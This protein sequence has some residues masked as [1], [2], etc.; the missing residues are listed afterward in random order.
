MVRITDPADP[1]VAEYVRVK[2]ADLVKRRGLFLAEGVEVVRT[3]VTRSR[4]GVR[5]LFVSERR[6]GAIADVLGALPEETPV[7]VASPEIMNRVVG[8]DIH[9]GCLA[10]GDR[11]RS[12]DL[13]DLLAGLGRQ[14]LL[15]VLEGIANHDNVGGVFRN[16]ACFGADAVLLD[17]TCADPLYR[18]AIRTS[19]GATLRVPFARLE[20]WPDALDTL[21]A[22]GFQ[23]FALTPREGG[24]ALDAVA[25]EQ[26]PRRALIL[27]TEGAGLTEPVLAAART[28]LRIPMAPGVDSLNVATASGIAM[29]WLRRRVRE[30]LRSSSYPE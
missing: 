2:E 19:M 9:R 1:R 29:W 10:A 11:G 18:K 4:F 12:P 24:R 23:T 7:Y 3:L 13:D 6:V 15:V 8:F 20:P 27:G 21:H 5:S 25:V 14:S 17:P 16:A 22:R 26:A 30:P 28:W